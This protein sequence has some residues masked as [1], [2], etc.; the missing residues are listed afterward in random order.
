MTP[1]QAAIAP[2]VPAV[3]DDSV[4]VLWA[5]IGPEFLSLI[6]WSNDTCV[7]RLPRDHPLLGWPTCA[8]AK[9][10]QYGLSGNGLCAS[11]NLRW[12]KAGMPAVEEF[13]TIERIRL[14]EQT[15]QK[16]LV[17]ACERPWVT[18]KVAL[19]GTH[20]W[21]RRNKVVLPLEEFVA[22]P[23]I[24]GL[25]GFGRCDVASC[26]RDKTDGGPYCHLH[27]MRRHEQRRRFSAAGNRLEDWDERWWCRTAPSVAVLGEVSLRGLPD[28][29]VAEILYGVHQRIARG[30]KTAPHVIRRLGDCA[31]QV[32]CGSLADLDPGVLGMDTRAVHRKLLKDVARSLRHPDTERLKD[33]WDVT[34]F[35]G[36]GTL[37]FTGILQPWLREASKIWACDELPQRRG[38]QRTNKIR[39]DLRAI[40]VLSHSLHLQR[41]DQGAVPG[42][43]GRAD[44]TAFLNR[45]AYLQASGAVSAHQRTG[46]VRRL[47]VI[48]QRM[49][50]LNLAGAG[51]PLHGL[52]EDFA[53]IPGDVPKDPET[54]TGKDLPAEVMRFLAG[55]LGGLER[56]S[57]PEIRVAVEI[58]IDTGR[59]PAEIC[60]L[61][62]D[63]LDRDEQGKP[64]LI[65]DNFKA[66]R[67][68]RRL[69]ITEQTAAL[70][71]LQQQ[72]IRAR[73]PDEPAKHVKLLAAPTKN[74]HGQRAVT[75]MWVSQRHREWIDAMP[76]I[77]VPMT[78]EI[79]GKQV[80]T[81]VPFDKS[82]IILY[83]YRHT[84]AQRHADAGVP[85]DV[86]RE[87]MDHRQ[88]TTTQDYYRVGENRRRDAIERVTSMQFDRSGHRVWREAQTLLDDEHLRR[89]VGEVAVPYGTCSEP[90]NVAAGGHDCPVRFR[91]VGCAHFST[92]VSYLP[93]LESYLADLLRS[94]ERLRGAFTAADS[95]AKAEAMPSD[96]EITRIR[97]LI[98][99]INADIDELSVEDR[100][101]IEDAVGV[102]RRARN[103]IV[104]LGLPKI[105]QPL[106]DTR[107]NRTA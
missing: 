95:W 3:S 45:M 15:I 41:I 48:L 39:Y 64:V 101:E 50:T 99:R 28:R 19:C 97:R 61:G 30:V 72:Q 14:R 79:D 13:T 102:V 21:Q 9:C 100:A 91:C 88:L 71:V 17:P 36:T 98:S 77:E 83:A 7:V 54:E 42:A 69:P 52:P 106:S 105:N 58:L 93:D 56:A 43:L 70:I 96:E 5:A 12:R 44:I 84:Y 87:L 67:I 75:S 4:E 49:R 10:D 29:V 73:Y 11:C 78:V 24:V 53:L 65:Y 86:L 66:N 89:A 35:G 18:S 76:E 23:D 32:E 74:P 38:R 26:V 16:C 85:V 47:R 63:C 107:P 55:R 34:V 1:S 6:G 40:G 82:R 2:T 37:H 57:C 94:R 22:H 25:K 46:W 27:K 92:D 20:H 59:R 8:V 51:Q 68:G 31:R 81:M 62:L 103:N 104:G 90:S 33:E 60:E 80:R